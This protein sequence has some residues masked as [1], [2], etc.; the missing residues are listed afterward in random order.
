MP[1]DTHITITLRLAAGRVAA[2][3]VA[4]GRMTGAAGRLAGMR[5]EQVARLLPAVFSLCGTA[6]AVAGLAA[7][8][9]AAGLAPRHLAAR[10]MLVL[11]ETLAEHGLAL[12]RDWPALLGEA[13][14]LPAAKILR[15][16]ATGLKSLLYPAGD[17]AHPGGGA[18]APL[19]ADIA[20]ALSAARQALAALLGADP[21][22][23]VVDFAGW[24]ASAIAPAARLMAILRSEGLTDFGRA[25]FDPMP[26]A[27]PPDLL[28]RL[29]A[30]H[31]GGYVARPE[32]GG[33]VFETGPL[34]RRASHAV[35][36]AL[37][38]RHGNG[39]LT[40]FAARVVEATEVLRELGRLSE[41][42]LSPS[43]TH[44]PPIIKT[45]MGVGVVEAARGLLVH[46]VRLD[47]GVVSRY[48]ILAPTEWN[49]HPAG[50][51]VQ[52]LTGAAAGAQLDRN[53]AWAVSALDPCV[54]C[55]LTM[56]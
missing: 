35:V 33:V 22:Q 26:A 4:S 5:P 12:A 42:L 21:D 32:C 52:G 1:F 51:L 3:R 38:A 53:A 47:N 56:E 54:A 55:S 37:L 7:L 34:A 6:Q 11:G 23:A 16:T 43:P 17:W 24:S 10:R 48:Q 29:A 44:A 9:Q 28:S 13:P 15:N 2:V 39:L 45:G 36:A 46:A 40:R 30:D 25:A 50:I 18:L 19:H 14:L 8:E 20:T 31:D 27:G 41:D 49:F